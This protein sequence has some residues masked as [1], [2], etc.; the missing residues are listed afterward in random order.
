M[1]VTN[2]KFRYEYDMYEYLWRKIFEYIR[3]SEYSSHYDLCLT[4]RASLIVVFDI[5]E[6]QGLSHILFKNIAHVGSFI[7]L[8]CVVVFIF[9]FLHVCVG[10]LVEDLVV[11]VLLLT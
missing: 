8:V 1:C 2:M 4:L 5:L 11:L 9:V 3:I 6:T 7:K 10:L